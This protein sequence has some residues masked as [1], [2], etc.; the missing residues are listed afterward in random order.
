MHQETGS[1]EALL[2]EDLLIQLSAQLETAAPWRDR[3]PPAP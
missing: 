1:L 3:Q 2:A